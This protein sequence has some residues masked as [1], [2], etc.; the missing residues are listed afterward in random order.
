[1]AAEG[2]AAMLYQTKL[3]QQKSFLTLSLAA[4]LVERHELATFKLASS[5]FDLFEVTRL[6]SQRGGGGWGAD[7][8][9][10]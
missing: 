7:T 8:L 2:R 3:L 9:N 4:Q 6:R 1:M 10:S 5:F